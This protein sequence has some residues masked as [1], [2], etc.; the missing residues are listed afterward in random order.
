M[1]NYFYTSAKGE[2]LGPYNEGHLL[3]MIK[4][5]LVEP[6]TPLETDTGTRVTVGQVL[7]SN[8]KSAGLFDI[9][10]TRFITNTWISTIWG[11]CIVFTT[12]VWGYET[13]TI[14][15]TGKGTGWFFT[16]MLP[17]QQQGFLV[18]F[19]TFE[20]IIGLLITRVMLELIIAIFR[21]EMHLRAIREKY[22]N[23]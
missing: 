9:G 11:F 21:I 7:G 14:F 20:A 22:E 17:N 13:Y 15:Q 4:R 10:F 16:T 1:A 2:K 6:D 12:V 19:M 8:F 3:E 5:K 23:K 18:L